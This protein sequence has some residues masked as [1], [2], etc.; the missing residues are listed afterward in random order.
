MCTGKMSLYVKLLEEKG[1]M[2]SQKKLKNGYFILRPENSFL[3]FWMKKY[4]KEMPAF[5]LFI[6]S[7]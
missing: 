4:P 6:V 7:F 5:I 3:F 1:Q 2:Y